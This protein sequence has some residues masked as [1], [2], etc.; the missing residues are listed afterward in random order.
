ML[1]LLDV[2]PGPVLD[3]GFRLDHRCWRARGRPAQRRPGCPPSSGSAPTNCSDKP[4]PWARIEAARASPPADAVDRI[5]VSAM[6]RPP[7]SLVDQL[8]ADGVIVVPVRQRH[9]AR[10]CPGPVVTEHGYYQSS[11]W[12][13]SPATPR[14][15]TPRRSPGAPR[16]PAAGAGPRRARPRTTTRTAVVLE[17]QVD[18]GPAPAAR[19]PRGRRSAAGCRAARRGV[20]AVAQVH[21]R[22]GRLGPPARHVEVGEVV[23]GPAASRAAPGRPRRRRAAGAARR[24]GRA[25]GRSRPRSGTAPARAPPATT[26]W[27]ASSAAVVEVARPAEAERVALHGQRQPGVR[28]PASAAPRQQVE[29][30]DRPR[31][32]G[33]RRRARRARGR[34]ARAR[35]ATRS[36]HHASTPGGQPPGRGEADSGGEA[37]RRQ[38]PSGRPEGRRWIG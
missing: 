7:R 13:A 15:S 33:R 31:G 25:T 26:A 34:S 36:S 20:G 5:L 24:R 6:P 1:H 35:A 12:S 23:G 2:R 9:A 29:H 14:A 32:G 21:Q 19:G 11:R 4:R 8:A 28:R 38:H 22:V 16:A 27:P 3:A 30:R 18:D 17:R 10:G 37:T